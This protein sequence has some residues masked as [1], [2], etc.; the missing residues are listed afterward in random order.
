MV[1]GT[2]RTFHVVSSWIKPKFLG[3]PR[4]LC[5]AWKFTTVC[6]LAEADTA[7]A[8]LLVDRMWA[9]TALATCVT[10]NLELWLTCSLNFE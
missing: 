4:S 5:D 7:D 6:H 1:S 8:E 9:T 2:I 3:L 10:T